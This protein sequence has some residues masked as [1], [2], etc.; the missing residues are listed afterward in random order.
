MISL[1][2]V[3]QLRT[4][5]NVSAKMVS[6]AMEKFAST[7]TNVSVDTLF[8]VMRTRTAQTPLVRMNAHAKLATRATGSIAGFLTF[9]D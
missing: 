7:S 3:F 5:V 9:V 6:M 2:S 1:L 4:V 8:C